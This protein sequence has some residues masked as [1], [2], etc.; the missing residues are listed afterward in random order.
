MMW[1]RKSPGVPTPPPLPPVVRMDVLLDGVWTPMELV[2]G[3]VWRCAEYPIR[4]YPRVRYWREGD[5][6]ARVIHPTISSTMN[7]LLT[8]DPHGE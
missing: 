4:E 7:F 1:K 6:A 5:D 8:V 3:G 2:D